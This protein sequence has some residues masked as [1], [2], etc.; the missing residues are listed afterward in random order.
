LH[1]SDIFH[2]PEP[3]RQ[4]H[5]WHRDLSV[6]GGTVVIR[7]RTRPLATWDG[8]YVTASRCRFGLNRIPGRTDGASQSLPPA[9][10]VTEAPQAPIA[11]IAD[12]RSVAWLARRYALTVLPAVSSLTSLRR[13]AEARR[14]GKPFVGFGDLDFSGGNTESVQVKSCE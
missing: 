7:R 12:Y 3:C 5:G 14:A 9:V 4:G 1:P 13:F 10:R 6:R 8:L 11:A 2:R